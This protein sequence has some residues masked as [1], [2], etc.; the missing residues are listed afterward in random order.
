MSHIVCAQLLAYQLSALLSPFVSFDMCPR[1][2]QTTSP[3]YHVS[4][5]VLRVLPR[6]PSQMTGT[7]G[8]VPAS[9]FTPSS[10]QASHACWGHLSGLAA[11]MKCQALWGSGH[12]PQC[13]FPW[14]PNTS[15]ACLTRK[16]RTLCLLSPIQRWSF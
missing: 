6:R 11:A 2:L 9:F 8:G 13:D 1:G 15:Y 10:K 14:D 5:L 7:V 16:L 3:D 4:Q 12:Q